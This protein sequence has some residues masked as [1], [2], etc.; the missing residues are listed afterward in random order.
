MRLH[1]DFNHVRPGD[2]KAVLEYF[3]EKYKDVDDID[4]GA[5]SLYVTTRDKEDNSAV[6][7]V[8]KSGK[9]IEWIIKTKEYKN[10]KKSKSD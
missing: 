7:F 10:T 8:S 3:Y 2:V 9:E 5:I 1:F 4:F 6:S